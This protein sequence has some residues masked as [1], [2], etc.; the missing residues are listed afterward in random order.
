MVTQKTY[1]LSSVE[2]EALRGPYECRDIETHTINKRKV[3]LVT[4][5]PALPGIDCGLG[6][7]GVNKVF[8]LARHSDKDLAKLKDFPIA[9]HVII[10]EDLKSPLSVTKKW[11]EMINVGWAELYSSYDL[12]NTSARTGRVSS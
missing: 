11:S 12:A 10:P 7:V 5:S 3:F 2:Y 9:V 1:Y 8:L 4:I 6:F